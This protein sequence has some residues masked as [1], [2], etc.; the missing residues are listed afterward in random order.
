[1]EKWEVKAVR[2]VHQL[3]VE[4]LFPGAREFAR[5][6]CTEWKG[7]QRDQNICKYIVHS[8]TSQSGRK[9]SSNVDPFERSEELG[10]KSS[11]KCHSEKREHAN[12]GTQMRCT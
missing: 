1:M 4:V 11:L 8:D 9:S 7:E 6:N 3:P 5:Q 10:T 2:M 12:E